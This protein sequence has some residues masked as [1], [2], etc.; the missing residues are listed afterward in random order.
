MRLAIYSVGRLKAGPDRE[1]FE[2]YWTRAS[3]IAP[4]IGVRFAKVREFPE[5]RRGDARDRRREETA[6]LIGAIA[7]DTW[8]VALH[9]KGRELTSRQL[10]DTIRAQM[11][12]GAAEIAFAIGG[13]DGHDTGSLPA[14]GMQLSLGRLT[15]P[16]RLVRIMLAEQLYRAMTIISGHPYHRD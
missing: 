16:H 10:A 14:F 5:S 11:E 12:Q 15:W 2:H 1:M 3:R 9:E 4:S 8:S 13:P 6:A 7:P